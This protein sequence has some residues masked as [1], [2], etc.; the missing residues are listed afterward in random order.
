MSTSSK[1]VHSAVAA[2]LAIA[3][4]QVHAQASDSKEPKEKCYGIAKA[5]RTIA[6]S[7]CAPGSA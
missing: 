7:A 5:G 6:R 3:T 4:S 2:I 1:L